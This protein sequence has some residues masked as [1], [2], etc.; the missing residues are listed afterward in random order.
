M[1]NV[2][3]V[4]MQNF[5]SLKAVWVLKIIEW[6]IVDYEIIKQVIINWRGGKQSIKC[7][8]DLT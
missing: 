6:T 3:T 4:L 7:A 1:L 8:Q 2:I 5:T